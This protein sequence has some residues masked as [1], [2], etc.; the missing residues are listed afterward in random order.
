MPAVCQE[1]VLEGGNSGPIGL[2]E[3]GFLSVEE[4]HPFLQDLLGI[5]HAYPVSAEKFHSVC[6]LDDSLTDTGA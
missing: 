1:G 5:F 3:I 6:S 4:I 2:S